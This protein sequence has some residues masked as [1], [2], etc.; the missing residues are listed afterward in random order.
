MAQSVSGGRGSGENQ[1]KAR[2][3]KLGKALII[4][5]VRIVE[6]QKIV[7]IPVMKYIEKEVVY[8]KPVVKEVETTK[9]NVVE[10]ETTKYKPVEKETIFYTPKMVEVEK[11]VVVLKTYERP[12]YENV[13][14]EKPVINEKVY[15]I[16]TV[17]DIDSVKQLI[18]LVEKLN[19]ELP[20]LKE[21]LDSLK[22][23]KLV[24]EVITVPKIQ[25]TT[26]RAERIEWVPV[27]K[28]MPIKE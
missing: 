18:S 2:D 11:P 25:W 19:L 1:Y 15:D 10:K 9:Y 14:Y 28:E 27:K 22:E 12:V 23:Y 21:N 16:A 7:D 5:D 8:E 20:K 4:E 6:R 17:K 24:E 13:S 26:V 3:E